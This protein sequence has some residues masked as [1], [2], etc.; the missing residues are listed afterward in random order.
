MIKSKDVIKIYIIYF[1]MK[2]FTNNKSGEP[3]DLE[4]K[5]GKNLS[6]IIP[7][8]KTIDFHIHHWMYFIIILNKFKKNNKIKNFCI[9]GILHGLMYQDSLSII[10]KKHQDKRYFL[11]KIKK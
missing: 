6:I 10:K 5:Y 2:I 4:K 9:A 3:N 7:F 11:S 1:L 8:S